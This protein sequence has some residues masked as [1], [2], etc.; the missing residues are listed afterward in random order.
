MGIPVGSA[1]C[2][3]KRSTSA[4]TLIEL[5]ISMVI[6]GILASLAV[7]KFD[8]YREQAK[9]RSSAH[10]VFQ[11]LSWARLQSEKQ[12]DTLLI[13]F[14]LPNIRVYRDVNGSGT[15]DVPDGVPILSETVENTVQLITPTA[16]PVEATG[17]IS[18]GL[19][20][21]PVTSPAGACG[22]TICCDKTGSPTSPSWKNA[23]VALCM[24]SM[25]AMPSL[26][27]DGAIFLGS[28]KSGV[29]ERWAI[30]MNR[31]VSSNPS[32]W[33]S[34]KAPATSADWSRVR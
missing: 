7:V 32:L 4:L 14:A 17:S 24:R 27:E 10:K 5:L 28:T 20:D 21:G 31:T 3:S 29:V 33:T 2:R 8:T 9:L 1:K 30:V 15:I 23:V 11:I 19:A 25:P 13:Q 34:S 22:P 16:A 26:V 12:G 18:S 6:M